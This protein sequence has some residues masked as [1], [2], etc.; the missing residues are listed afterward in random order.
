[1]YR[2]SIGEPYSLPK[3]DIDRSFAFNYSKRSTD[4][5]VYSFYD[6]LTGEVPASTFRNSIVL[7][8]DDTTF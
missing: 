8:G 2:D 3:L 7:V 5:T 1:M 4:Y 6:V